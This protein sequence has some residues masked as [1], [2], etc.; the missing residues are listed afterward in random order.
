M[1]QRAIYCNRT[2]NLRAVRAIGYDMDYTLIHYDVTAWERR[3]YAHLKQKLV[4]LGWPVADLEFDPELIVRGLVLDVESGNVVK[5]NRFGYVNRAFHGTSEMEFGAQRS[6]YSR[7]IVDLTD[8]RYVFLNTL[9]DLSK[10]CMY[11]QLVDLLD[12]R[13]LPDV[14]GYRDL[15]EHVRRLIDEAHMEGMLKA[16]IIAAPER[17]VELDDE[18]PLALLDQ[19]LSGKRLLLITNSEWGYT[20]AMMSYA[21]DRFLP[22]GRTWRDLF[23]VVVVEARKPS[24]FSQ[25]NA[26]FEVVDEERGLLAPAQALRAGAAFLGGS[27]TAVETLLDLSGDQ[28]LYV[29]DHLFSDVHQTKS[30]LRWRTALVLREIDDDLAA[31][32]AS[33]DEHHTLT[34]KMGEKSALEAELC[35]TRLDLQR[36]REGYGPKPERS[37]HALEARAT[38]LRQRLTDLD[39]LIAP[40]ATRAGRISNP[41]WG[42]LMRAGNDKSLLARQVERHADIYMSRVSCFLRETPFAFLRSVPGTLPHDVRE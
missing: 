29:G 2:L 16:E 20:Q 7:A 15:Y 33:A 1:S 17:F 12:R 5:P 38:E 4:D 8:P 11:A 28:I 18:T 9:F 23:D 40:L 32:A 39:E 27:A 30:L 10:G 3:A 31:T 19:K 25:H 14:M 36:L 37:R 6:V 21:F 26:L 13:V 34:E 41:R 42:L 24:F 22:G 35:V